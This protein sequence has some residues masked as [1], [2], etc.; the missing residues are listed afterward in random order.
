MKGVGVFVRRHPVL[1]FVSRRSGP[2]P[3]HRVSCFTKTIEASRAQ[4][5]VRAC[6]RVCVCVCSKNKSA[7]E[8]QV[9]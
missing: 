5:G 2:P 3:S 9:N 8:A 4:L 7:C 6:V 1:C